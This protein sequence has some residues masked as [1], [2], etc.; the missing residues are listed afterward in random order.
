MPERQTTTI[1]VVNEKGGCGKSTTS[2]NLAAGLALEGH[3]TCLV[4]LDQQ[5]NT[6]QTFA[7]DPD[8]LPKEGRFS[9]LDIFLGKKRAIDIEIPFPDRFEG[10]LT[11]IP[12]SRGLGSVHHRLEAT[13][14][15]ELM[16]K[17]HSIIVADELR[18]EH[19]QRLK[20]SLGSLKGRRD[21]VILDTPGDLGFQ[22][23]T[24][25]I[26]ADYYLIPVFPS[27]YDLQGL[28]ALT[29]S[30]AKVREKLNPSLKFLGVLFGRV[31]GRARLDADI[32]AN[33]EEHL[34]REHVLQ[35]IISN[36]VRVREA[37]LHNETIF[38]Y[39]PTDKTAEQFKALTREVLDKLEVQTGEPVVTM[40]PQAPPVAVAAERDPSADD[41]ELT[42]GVQEKE[43][44]NA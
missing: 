17:S 22:V 1:A 41:T 37:P 18:A 4:D 14:Q 39:D 29:A 15:A 38:E 7:I 6:T 36:S 23:T 35:T 44:G 8:E 43:V 16:E 33:L 9:A 2:V 30:I 3:P 40:Q 34:G 25:L 11:L 42:P 31:D 32:K 13:M 28:D 26:A 10:R 19:R 27:G 12:G 21:F 24:A 20:R 5:V